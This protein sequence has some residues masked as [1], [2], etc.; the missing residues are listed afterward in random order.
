VQLNKDDLRNVV[1]RLPKDVRNMLVR[2][3]GKVFVGGGFIRAIVGRE[4]VSDIDMFGNNAALLGILAEKLVSG[5]KEF[6]EKCRLHTTKNAITI[7]TENRLPVQMI[8]RW[9][10]ESSESLIGSF[11]FT[12]CASAVYYENGEFRSQVSPDFYS[13]LAAKRL[14]YTNPKREEEAGGSMLR[15]LKYVKRGYSISPESLADVMSRVHIAAVDIQEK[16]LKTDGLTDIQQIT[17]QLLREVDPLMVVD[18]LDI[19]DDHNMPDMT[20]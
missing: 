20:F 5:R 1:L 10:F 13:D 17:K 15:V 12:V 19:Q 9:L 2:Y 11:D 8:T 7:L 16:G 6:N 18:G 3:P 14:R 4:D